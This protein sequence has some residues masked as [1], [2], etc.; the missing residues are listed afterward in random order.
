LLLSEAEAPQLSAGMASMVAAT[1]ATAGHTGHDA[2]RPA[3]SM[4]GGLPAFID[5][6]AKAIHRSGASTSNV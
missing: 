3:N 1:A 6:R 5:A 4:P 2:A